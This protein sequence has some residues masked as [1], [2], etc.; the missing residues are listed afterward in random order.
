VCYF[1]IERAIVYMVNRSGGLWVEPI[2]GATPAVLRTS[3]TIVRGQCVKCH[4]AG[5]DGAPRIGDREAWIPRLKK[6][7]D[8]LVAS[9]IHGHGAMPTRGGMPDLSDQELRGAIVYMFN[10]GLPATPVAAPAAASTDPFHKVVSGTDVYLGVITAEALR[11]AQPGA[12]G[13]EIPS[14]KGHYHINISLAD[15]RSR[16]PV[17]DAEVTV[18]VSDGMS[19]E[20][21][22]L[23]LVAANNTVSY[24]GYFRLSAGSVYNVT[25]EIRRPGVAGAIEA[26]F[27]LK[28][29]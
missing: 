27:R 7:L 3:E 22:S 11:A 26:K 15:N 2:G 18:R 21:R 8:A 1:D 9:A 28:A 14:G 4:E 10:F 16:V 12:P 23:G 6:G 17:T 20:T 25:A 19:I 29:P 5:K 24:G 13:G